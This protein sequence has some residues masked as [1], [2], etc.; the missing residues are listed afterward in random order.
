MTFRFAHDALVEKNVADGQ[1]DDAEDKDNCSENYGKT[2][3][4]RDYHGPVAG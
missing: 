2:S 4:G 1:D 3:F